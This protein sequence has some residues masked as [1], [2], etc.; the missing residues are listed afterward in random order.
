MRGCIT[1]SDLFVEKAFDAFGLR[2]ISGNLIRFAI[3]NGGLAVFYNL[4]LDFI[5]Y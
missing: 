3:S 2:L 4:R 5:V 1:V